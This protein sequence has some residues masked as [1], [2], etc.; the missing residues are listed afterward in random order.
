MT[1]PT[2][3]RFLAGAL[4]RRRVRETV[5]SYRRL[6]DE[7][8]GGDVD[9]RRR[10]SAAM[11]TRYYD[12]VTDF[13]E[14]GWGASFHF[15]PR[16]RAESFQASLARSEMYVAHWLGLRPGMRALDLG[17]GVGGPM[18]TIARFSGAHITGINISRYQIGRAQK[19][20]HASQL[21]HLCE[22]VCGD[23]T[24]LPL[25]A[26]RFDA[27]YQ[28]EATAH[29][30]DRRAVFAEVFRVLKPGARFVGYDWCLTDRYDPA[31]AEHRS[32]KKGIEEGT[33]LPDLYYIPDVLRALAD[34]GFELIESHDHALTADADG[35]W[36]RALAGGPWWTVGGFRASRVGRLA[37]HGLVRTLESIRVLP[38]GA[39]EVS[40]L[41]NSGAEALVRGGQTGI[42]TPM[43]FYCARKPD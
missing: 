20:N 28:I 42:F 41:L 30:P 4:P 5:D 40:T 24:T 33:S 31:S 38:P 2:I 12:L 25:P 14:Y 8:R 15:A 21:T 3:S 37:T 43:F 26:A 10:D 9:A 23:F 22:V 11:T 13:Y 19:H 35:A 27:A 34:V 29:A 18:R 1:R 17:C 6:H 16:H 36:W 7:S 39:T 32:I